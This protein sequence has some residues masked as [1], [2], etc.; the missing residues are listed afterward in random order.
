VDSIGSGTFNNKDDIDVPTGMTCPVANFT[1]L[2]DRHHYD[3][4]ESHRE[5]GRTIPPVLYQTGKDRCVPTVLYEASIVQWFPQSSSNRTNDV[6]DKSDSTSPASFSSSP[7]AASLSYHYFDDEAM[8]EYLYDNRWVEEFPTLS[9]ALKCIEHVQMPVMKADIWRYLILWEKGGIFADLDVL[10]NPDL[11][12]T[13]VFGGINTRKQLTTD[14]TVGKMQQRTDELF[15]DNDDAVFVLVDQDNQ[16]VLSQWFLA[17]SPKHPLMRYAVEEAAARVLKAKRAI[18][19]QHTGPRALYLATDKFLSAPGSFSSASSSSTATTTPSSSAGFHARELHAGVTYYGGYP[20][21]NNMVVPSQSIDQSS[22]V[23]G[24]INV[25]NGRRSFRVLPSSMARNNAIREQK[26]VGYKLMNM[27]HYTNRR[28]GKTY[29]GK[30]CLEF[31]NGTHL[32][33]NLFPSFEYHGRIYN[34]SKGG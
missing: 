22:N 31:L 15:D 17:T 11:V 18:P 27:T 13:L 3:A 32:E 19:I 16:R 23:V 12:Q 5:G 14:H 10:P 24:N 30:T 33:T 7:A 6:V 29:G 8:D 9:L 20:I 2:S 26:E 34:F 1:R 21:T 28:S 4:I 25:Q